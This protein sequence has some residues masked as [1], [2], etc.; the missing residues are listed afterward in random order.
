MFN[1]EQKGG[2]SAFFGCSKKKQGGSREGAA[3]P[4]GGFG[5]GGAPPMSSCKISEKPVKLLQEGLKG[6]KV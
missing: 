5:G 1:K 4:A 3:I 2:L 6:Q